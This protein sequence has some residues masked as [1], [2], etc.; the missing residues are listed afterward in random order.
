MSDKKYIQQIANLKVLLSEANHRANIHNQKSLV[1]CQ[2]CMYWMHGHNEGRSTSR[3]AQWGTC[4]RS[5]KGSQSINGVWFGGHIGSQYV[6]TQ[7]NF[8]C[9][10]GTKQ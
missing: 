5:G 1:T 6:T 4:Q 8:A 7:K 10:L 2:E 9:N 3:D